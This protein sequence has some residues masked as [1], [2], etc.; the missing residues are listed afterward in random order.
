MRKKQKSNVILVDFA[1]TQPIPAERVREAAEETCEKLL[2]IGID[3]DGDPYYASSFADEQEML[4][5][6]ERFKQKLLLGKFR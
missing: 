5:L 6:I 2:C 4:W 3:K 1:T